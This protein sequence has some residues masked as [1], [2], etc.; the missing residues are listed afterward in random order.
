MLFGERSVT[1]PILVGK[2]V[3]NLMFW[4]SEVYADYD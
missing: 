3:G 1:A 4:Y 2:N